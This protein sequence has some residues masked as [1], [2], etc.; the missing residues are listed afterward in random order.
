LIAARPIEGLSGQESKVG[1]T[2]VVVFPNQ[3][4]LWFDVEVPEPGGMDVSKA[5]EYL[6]HDDVYPTTV[7]L[8]PD[9]I[10]QRTRGG[11]QKDRSTMHIEPTDGHNMSCMAQHRQPDY[12][13]DIISGY[14]HEVL[15]LYRCIFAD[16]SKAGQ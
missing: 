3:N 14:G 16:E 7:S 12:L 5:M 9:E 10:C 8:R 4:V 1:N 11:V 6:C 15:G 13:F 2:H